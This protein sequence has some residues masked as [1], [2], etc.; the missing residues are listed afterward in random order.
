MK[1]GGSS[2]ADAPRLRNVASLVLAAHSGA[3]EQGILVVLS[4]LGGA[5]DALIKAGKTAARGEEA[6]SLGLIE[7]LLERHAQTARDLL[8]PS[9]PDLVEEV[10]EA[11][12]REVLPLL[13]GAALLKEL[14]ARS[15]DLIAGRGELLSSALLAAYMDQASPGAAWID[16]R[17]VMKT[18]SR[19]G[20]ARPDTQAIK[21]AA[22]TRLLPLLGEG[23]IVVTQ[24]YIGS[25]PYQT[26]TTLG[27]GGSDYSASL[28][29]AAVVAQEIQI[30][31]D[32][33]GVLTCDPRIVPEARPVEVLGYDEAAE[34]AAFGA[35]VL[36]PAT[37]LPAVELG[38]PVT[39]RN[40]LLPQGRFTTISREGTRGRAVTALASR[41]P[42]TVL[43]IRS[44]GMLGGTGFLARIFE[45]FGRL[46]VSVDLVSTSEV[47]V[48]V[49]VDEGAPLEALK[50]ELS[51]FSEVRVEE[52]RAVV[53][54][55]GEALRRT[56][57]IAGRA[58]ASLGDINVEMISMGASEINLS[59]V[60]AR[61]VA[62]EAQRRLHEAFFS[63]G[64]RP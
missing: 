44:P 46:G 8:G 39:V 42:I 11:A 53:A 12:R 19:F 36:H 4:A 6:E 55:V 3:P 59:L 40:S 32:V 45:V 22:A 61:S 28:F 43:S 38:I 25:D 16:A 20:Q 17:Q 49:T 34:L 62:P 5:T 21:S 13:R 51:T 9:L 24:G 52:D 26:P 7:A 48:S 29:G 37:I 57:G 54:L 27:R 50:K 64:A 58:L 35:K 41:G 33:E 23:R 47:T 1:F 31:T 30:W 2:V 10:L 15:A 63:P 56:P 14:P 18:D 60:V